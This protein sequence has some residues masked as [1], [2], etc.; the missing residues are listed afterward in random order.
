MRQVVPAES[1]ARA[2][3]RRRWS[4]ERRAPAIASGGD[5]PRK[6]VSGGFRRPPIGGFARLRVSRRSAS[7]TGEREGQKTGVPRASTKNRGDDAWLADNWIAFSCHSGARLK[8]ANPESITPV[9]RSMDSGPAPNT[10]VN[11]LMRRVPE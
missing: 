5:T 8:A 4:A 9:L 11:A 2:E 1:A 7:L 6:R 3:K 10:R